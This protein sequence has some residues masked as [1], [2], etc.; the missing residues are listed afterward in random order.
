MS[1]YKVIYI[2][3][4]YHGKLEPSKK[5]GDNYFTFGSLKTS[6]RVF[7]GIFQNCIK[8]VNTFCIYNCKSS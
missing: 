7:I 8:V 6:L 2:D 5:D 3:R 1:S 4:V